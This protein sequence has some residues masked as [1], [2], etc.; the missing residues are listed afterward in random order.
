MTSES[1]A[2][3]LTKLR[4]QVANK[5]RE[6]RLARGWTQAELGLRLGL[7]QAR[8]SEIERGR[9]SFSAE[10]LLRLLDDFNVDISV[11][12]PPVDPD[13]EVQNAL[14]QRGALHLRQTPGA[15]STGRF[16]TPTELIAAVLLDPRSTRF[17]TAL[18][19]VLVHEIEHISLP[20]L[21]AQ[22]AAAGREARLGWFLD[23]V[24]SVLGQ[25]TP[26]NARLKKNLNRT[27]T[28]LNNELERF[29]PPNEG[30]ATDLFDATIR[31]Q[32]SLDLVWKQQ[33]SALSRRWCIVTAI[34]PAD[35]SAA[36]E[37]ANEPD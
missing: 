31:S 36:F 22:L 4:D 6:L 37:A 2:S 23:N 24:R 32:P 20:L 25:H 11:F 18:A 12:L 35:F 8:L 29:A 21:R 26:K 19:P 5:V 17:V 33:A 27:L 14:I 13:A 28:L 10:Q 34:Q 1:S 7:S 3:E 15:I 9:G 16:R 30:S